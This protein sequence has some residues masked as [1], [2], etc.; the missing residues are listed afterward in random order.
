MHVSRIACLLLGAW[1]GGSMFMY[2][3]ATQNFRSV[4]RTLEIDEP[5]GREAVKLLGGPDAA[6]AFLRFHVGEQNRFY[7]VG[8]EYV[9]LGI[10]LALVLLLLFG[11]HYRKRLVVVSVLMLAIVGVMRFTVTPSITS[12]GRELDFLPAAVES[13]IRNQFRAWHSAYAVLEVTKLVFGG[14]LA[15]LLVSANGSRRRIAKDQDAMREAR[16]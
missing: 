5:G 15:I 1:I 14:I 3:V 8:W 16:R 9:Q 4:E 12:L 10:G 7:F 2:A 13:P 11:D 6:R